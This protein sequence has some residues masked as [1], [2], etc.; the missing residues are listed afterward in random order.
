MLSPCWFR[1]EHGPSSPTGRVAVALQLTGLL[2]ETIADWQKSAFKGSSTAKSTNRYKWCHIGLYH[3]STHPNYA[4]EWLFWLGSL[5]AGIVATTHW[6]QWVMMLTGF[7]FISSVLRGAVVKLDERQWDKYGSLPEY[8]TF[9]DRYGVFGPR[10][11]HW[12]RLLLGNGGVK[13]QNETVVGVHIVN[14]EKQDNESNEA[15]S[16]PATDSELETR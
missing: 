7:V 3:F 14:D 5:M 8:A 1:L 2:L 16:A 6:Q 12:K 9:R 10:L 15:A 13:T 11:E 4:G